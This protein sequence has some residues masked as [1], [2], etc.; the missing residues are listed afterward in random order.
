METLADDQ[1]DIYF[2]LVQVYYQTKTGL[3]CR[4][5]LV[6]GLG[7]G[8]IVAVMEPIVRFLGEY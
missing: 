6:C 2:R 8:S 3:S 1:N 7:A 5:D 4:L